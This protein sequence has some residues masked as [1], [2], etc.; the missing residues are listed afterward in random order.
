MDFLGFDKDTQKNQK[1]NTLDGWITV[2][3]IDWHPNKGDYVEGY[4]LEKKHDVG[5]YKQ[6]LYIIQTEKGQK[7]AVWGKTQLD[8][9][10]NEV[11]VDDYIRIIFNGT[12]KTQNN[13]KM[14]M[15][16]VKVR[17]TVEE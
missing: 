15:Y 7:V 9:M 3:A 17:K 12:R 5:Q 11:Y 2:Q 8:T 13:K 14:K 1:N 10:M 16:T 4:L 6:N